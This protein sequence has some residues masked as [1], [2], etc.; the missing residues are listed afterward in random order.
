MKAM[1]W[2]LVGLISLLLVYGSLVR[3]SQTAWAALPAHAAQQLAKHPPTHVIPVYNEALPVTRGLPACLRRMIRPRCYSPQQIRRAYQIQPLLNAGI[4]GKGQ[5]IV[6]V[7]FFQSPSVRSD[8]RLFDQLFHLPEPQLTIYAPTGLTPFNRKSK[9]QKL[10]AIETSL[11]VEW[12]H[13]I[14]PGA[15]IALVLSRSEEYEDVYAATKFAIEQHLGSVL[16]Q[17]F[18]QPE[19]TLPIEFARQEHELFEEAR[20]QGMSVFASSGD[21]GTLS[22]IY[23]GMPR[24]V[25]AI[26][27]GVEYPASDP[28]VTSVGGTSLFLDPGGSYAYESVWSNRSGAPG[29]GFSHIFA[30]PDYQEGITGI[31]NTRSVPDVAYVGDPSTGVLVVTTILTGR[32]ATSLLEAP[33]R[34]HRNGPPWPHSATS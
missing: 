3:E 34:A 23:G 16:S 5:T 29:G 32:P 14:A 8:L 13:A 25:I 21:R 30:R 2:L 26:G 22:P 27:Q 33:A 18:G 24:R 6:I 1:R 17:S 11:D 10:A 31:G 20:A 12:A 19:S 15:A 4:T 7:D 9:T 28:L